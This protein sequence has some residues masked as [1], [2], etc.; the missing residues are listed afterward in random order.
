MNLDQLI[1]ALTKL[2]DDHQ[3]NGNE[4]HVF[5]HSAYSEED[6]YIES[7]DVLHSLEYGADGIVSNIKVR[8]TKES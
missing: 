5:I 7:V 2:R 8:L 3:L 1:A 6:E 4:V